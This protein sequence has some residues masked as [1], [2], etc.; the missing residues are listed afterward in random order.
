MPV[1]LDSGGTDNDK[2]IPAFV[3]VAQP[4]G[5]AQF[6][7][8]RAHAG[9]LEFNSR[10]SGVDDNV[11]YPICERVDAYLCE[12]GLLESLHLGEILL[13]SH[14]VFEIA[15]IY[16]VP[17]KFADPSFKIIPC[18]AEEIFAIGNGLLC[19]LLEKLLGQLGDLLSGIFEDVVDVCHRIGLLNLGGFELAAFKLNDLIEC[20]A[21]LLFF[22]GD[23]YRPQT[24]LL[25]PIPQESANQVM[26]GA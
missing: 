23:E 24:A 2:G 13:A 19:E 10:E 12:A 21:D 5:L 25:L 26:I 15:L 14:K 8:Q 7:N 22:F 4:V 20:F 6:L 9:A 16:F 1:A 17:F 11:K 18:L 3:I